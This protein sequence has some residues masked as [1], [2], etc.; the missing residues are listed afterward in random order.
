MGGWFSPREQS[1][2]WD[3]GWQQGRGGWPLGCL[4]GGVLPVEMLISGMGFMDIPG[5][6]GGGVAFD[7]AC[8]GE[9]TR[10]VPKVRF[11]LHAVN[12]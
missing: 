6:G 8:A 4:L 11:A 9:D 7:G 10:P 2:G 3:A 12:I 5:F 1:D